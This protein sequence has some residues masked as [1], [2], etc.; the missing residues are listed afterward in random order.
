MDAED[1][2]KDG[3]IDIGLG[4]YLYDVVKPSGKII[5]GLQLTYFKNLI[6]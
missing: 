6:R 1:M 2:D 3:D 5:P 4:N